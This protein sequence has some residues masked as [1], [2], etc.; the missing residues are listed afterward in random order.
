MDTFLLVA[1]VL[2]AL[3]MAAALERV[4]AG[5]TTF[6]RLIAVALVTVHGVVVIVLLAFVTGRLSLFLDIALAYA[7]LAF[8]FP[9]A[10]G[11]FYERREGT[12]D[13][14]PDRADGAGGDVGRPRDGEAGR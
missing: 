4:W 10:I 13:E 11:R 2:V 3:L 5:P 6:D 14:G 7:L 1:T 12:A 9:I 8:L